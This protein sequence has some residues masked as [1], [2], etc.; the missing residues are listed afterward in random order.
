MPLDTPYAAAWKDWSIS[1]TG[2]NL[3]HTVSRHWYNYNIERKWYN[4]VALKI[5]ILLQ[6]WCTSLVLGRITLAVHLKNSIS[7]LMICTRLDCVLLC[8]G[9]WYC[10]W[11]YNYVYISGCTCAYM[12]EW[13]SAL[14]VQCIMNVCALAHVMSCLFMCSPYAV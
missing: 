7:R 10:K 3:P 1:M 14:Y 6:H 8:V 11:F 12:M 13:D 4:N 2:V 9:M 5:F